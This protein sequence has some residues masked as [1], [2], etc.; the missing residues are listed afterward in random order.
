MDSGQTPRPGPQDHHGCRCGV[1]ANVPREATAGLAE[2]VP[3][4]PP[5]RRTTS[6]KAISGR[7]PRL[8]ALAH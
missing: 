7:P 4:R 8:W 3:V 1:G 6:P 5:A 2:R